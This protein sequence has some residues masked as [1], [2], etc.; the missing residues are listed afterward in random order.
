MSIQ[1]S[2]YNVILTIENISQVLI[3]WPKHQQA[4]IFL[5][6]ICTQISCFLQVGFFWGS[7]HSYNQQPIHLCWFFPISTQPEKKKASN[8]D[9]SIKNRST[10]KV[11]SHQHNHKGH[12]VCELLPP[13][14]NRTPRKL[15]ELLISYPHNT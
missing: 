5:I 8:I 14:I 9:I 13:C 6:T 2:I 7:Y 3:K 15:E 4:M 12:E 10:P 1:F 11:F